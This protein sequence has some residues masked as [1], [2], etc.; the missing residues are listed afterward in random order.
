MGMLK[1]FAGIASLLAIV[2]PSFVVAKSWNYDRRYICLT[3][4]A[5]GWKSGGKYTDLD[6]TDPQTQYIIEPFVVTAKYPRQ[7]KE[8]YMEIPISHTVKQ[9]GNDRILA[10]CE[11]NDHSD[12]DCYLWASEI[13]PHD[14]LENAIISSH[15]EFKMHVGGKADDPIFMTRNNYYSVLLSS[16][17]EPMIEIGVCNRF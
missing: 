1:V 15:I 5:A 3:S 8:G 9:V 13:K 14:D 7:A 2:L 17:R 11:D 6:L 10:L 12:L 16:E 4:Q